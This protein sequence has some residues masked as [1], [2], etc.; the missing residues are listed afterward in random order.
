MSTFP[1]AERVIRTYAAVP[2][3]VLC[4]A[5]LFLF[6]SIG[7]RS[8]IGPVLGATVGAVAAVVILNVYQP[9]EFDTATSLPDY[10]IAVIITC[11]YVFSIFTIYRFTLHEQPLSHYLVFGGFAG[12]IAYEIASGARRVR[13]VPQLL[14][15][16]FFTYWSVQLAFP[17][18]MNEPDT[19]GSYL[20]S[21]RSALSSGSFEGQINYLGH[22]IYVLETAIV[23]GLSPKMAYF[24][25]ATL[26]LTG[27]LLTISTLDLAFPAISRPVALYGALF[28]GCMGW[29]LGR[30]FHP[31]KLNFFYTLTLLLGFVAVIK[32]ASLSKK[33]QQMWILL[34]VPT[35]LALIFGHR[36]SAGAAM[37]FLVAIAAFT[38][39]A[40]LFLSSR[41]ERFAPWSA[42]AIAVGYV[43]AI[44]GNPIHQ[45]PLFGRLVGLITSVFFPEGSG[46]GGGGPG[47]YSELS[48]ELLL[49]STA[50]QAILFGLGVFG[51]AVVIRRHD[52]EFDLVIFWMGVLA[53]L[54]AVSLVFNA[55]D[56]QPQRFYSLLGLFGLNITAGAALIY[57]VKSEIRL[58][59]ARTAGFIVF[60]F[61]LLSLGSP[62][63]SMHLAFVSEDVPHN[64]LHDTNQLNAGED[65]VDQYGGNEETLLRTMPPTTE[66]PYE[67]D[68]GLTAVVNTTKIRPGDRYV[69]TQTAAETGV[70]STG[71]LGLG[72]RVFLFL[73]LQPSSTDNLIYE[74]GDTTVYQKT[75]INEPQD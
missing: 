65:W 31:N 41:Y 53:G 38:V 47:R 72:D 11:L 59:S 74:N 8:V 37:I 2:V 52:W 56:V 18:G 19:R 24:I 61:A 73:H 50:G 66:L 10:R 54:L 5:A 33:K 35:A 34:G 17:A 14:V 25:L 44:M 13:I 43:L 58:F 20:P 75:P 6:V 51:A 16:T 15:L 9:K 57:L 63:A 69:Y 30:G 4:S 3:V 23:T 21:I 22:L 12:Y 42:V 40:S 39:F 7:Y 48:L 67:R 46:S 27:T 70:R 55:A 64:R 71:G 68:S 1:Q 28:F 45:E 60:A 36:F 62:V 26:V 49:V 29:T 32:Y